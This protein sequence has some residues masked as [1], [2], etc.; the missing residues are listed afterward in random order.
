MGQVNGDLSVTNI[1][2]A[3]SIAISRGLVVDAKGY[4]A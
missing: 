4:T 1:Y 3:K 2:I